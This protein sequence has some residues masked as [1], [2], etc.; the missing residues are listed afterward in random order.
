[1]LSTIQQDPKQRY[2]NSW[3]KRPENSYSASSFFF[4]LV[5]YVQ[6]LKGFTKTEWGPPSPPAHPAPPNR[7]LLFVK[8][9][10]YYLQYIFWVSFLNY[11]ATIQ[12][13]SR[14]F[15]QTKMG[16]FV[17]LQLLSTWKG[18]EIVLLR[19]GE[20][21]ACACYSFNPDGK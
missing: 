10:P 7:P 14:H 4:F 13:H 2:L 21:W 16:Y 12:L 19:L 3:F 15:L 1:M 20:L 11:D 8:M 9:T 18:F 17:S 5:L 6:F